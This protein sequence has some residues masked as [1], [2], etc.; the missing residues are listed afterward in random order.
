MK[1]S[2]DTP[3][4]GDLKNNQTPKWQ[5]DQTVVFVLVE[6]NILTSQGSPHLSRR[7]E[8]GLEFIRKQDE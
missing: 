8:V 3:I 4:L 5:K 6:S 7:A 2:S 1:T